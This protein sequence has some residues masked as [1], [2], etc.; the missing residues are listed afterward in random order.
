MQAA[1]E[2]GFVDAILQQVGRS[3]SIETAANFVCDNLA[4]NHKD[5]YSK[6]SDAKGLAVIGTMDPSRAGAMWS[7]AGIN[8][9]CVIISHLQDWSRGRITVPEAQVRAIGNNFVP[10]TYGK[11]EYKKS[12]DHAPEVIDYWTRHLPDVL[13]DE[14]NCLVTDKVIGPADISHV[15]CVLGGEIDDC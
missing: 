1:K 15:G 4:S 10:A 7:D 2:S 5:T 6:V 14:L 11:Y 9:S 12:D 8:T 13:K 3:T